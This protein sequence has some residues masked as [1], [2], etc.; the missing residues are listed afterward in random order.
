MPREKCDASVR[1]LIPERVRGR[2][3]LRQRS[4][5]TRL[6]QPAS[7][8]ARGLLKSLPQ[9]FKRPHVAISGI[10]IRHHLV[11]APSND[12]TIRSESRQHEAKGGRKFASNDGREEHS[13]HVFK[14]MLIF[15]PIGS[16]LRMVGLAVAAV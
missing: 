11:Q 6:K 7:R 1:A 5:N 9:N 4:V 12:L 14:L 10:L 3:C 15:S 16:P 13:S 8:I 2:P